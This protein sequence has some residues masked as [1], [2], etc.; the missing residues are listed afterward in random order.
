M[1]TTTTMRPFAGASFRGDGM[2]RTKRNL[3]AGLIVLGVVT[4]ASRSLKARELSVD[5]IGLWADRQVATRLLEFEPAEEQD[6]ELFSPLYLQDALLLLGNELEQRGFIFAEVAVRVSRF[7]EAQEPVLWRVGNVNLPDLPAGDAVVFDV[8]RG[9]RAYLSTITFD[10]DLPM[11]TGDAESF[12]VAPS[13]LWGNRKARAYASG[14]LRQSGENLEATLRQE[15][16]QDASVRADVL[17]IDEV[18]GA[19]DIAVVVDRGP[20]FRVGS[21]SVEAPAREETAAVGA[22]ALFPEAERVRNAVVPFSYFWLQ[23]A[24][25]AAR[26]SWRRQGYPDV[27]LSAAQD[28]READGD[29]V[30]DVRLSVDPGPRVRVG[31]IRFTGNETTRESV[32]MRRVEIAPGD[33]FNAAEADE[34]RARLARLGIFER[35]D[36]R[37][38]ESPGGSGARDIEFV[39]RELPR[40]EVQ[41]LFGYG[42]YEQ[43]RGGVQAIRR[44]VG[45]RAHR[46]EMSLMQSFKSTEAD[47]RY[48]VP[49]LFGER[50][51]GSL[52]ARFL[53][54]EE[55]SFDRS[56][57]SAEML[58]EYGSARDIRFLG[59]YRIERLAIRD[60][61]SGL[62]DTFR[63]ST[64]V[65]TLFGRVII[66]RIDGPVSGRSQGW[67]AG[68]GLDW[69]DP[70]LG[71][72]V[73][74]QGLSADFV[75]H[76]PI[77]EQ[78]RG[79][80]AVRQDSV[81]TWGSDSRDIP[82]NRRLF[83]G[84]HHS[85]RGFQ[86]G[87]AA[88][89]DRNG[90]FVGAETTTL[91]SLEIERYLARSVDF[92]LFS[93]VLGQAESISDFPAKEW[94]V[95]AGAGI[96][97]RTP[98]GPLRVEYGRVLTKREDLPDGRLHIT[99]GAPF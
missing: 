7:G 8:D 47:A 25:Q 35:I 76:Q 65:G 58:L 5:G 61:S 63:E 39:L 67:R 74:Y 24:T 19:V 66:D 98:L 96:R 73:S 75:W 94:L 54:R 44:N 1:S 59:G 33:W 11:E 9:V 91:V 6:G 14:R 92:V 41:L 99:L 40:S 56:E 46:F 31:D 82:L 30:V 71:A 2:T 60:L 51:S 49:E 83:P 64:R 20:F 53:R 22:G 78:W 16:F 17:G 38:P 93:D 36:W 72:E 50:I 48:F 90:E 57:T 13:G 52:E 15:G 4:G 23:D 32:L 79:N 80:L 10:G 12:F 34:A 87:E 86:D 37:V 95:S 45:G 77:G 85:I 70:L 81:F 68:V 43:L 55:V 3:V 27:R 26:R 88:P 28:R 21:L 42:S 84:G 29:V 62:Q 69:S 18:T 89:R 97:L